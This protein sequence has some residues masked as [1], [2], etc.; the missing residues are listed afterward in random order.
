MSLTVVIPTLNEERDLPR[1]LKSLAN[2]KADILVIDSGS[3]DKTIEIAQ[4]HGAKI[5]NHPF[6]SFS[7]TRNFADQQIKSDWILSLEA[8]VVITKKLAQEIKSSTSEVEDFSAYYIP[9]QNIIWG[10]KINHTDWGPKDDLHIWLYKKGAGAWRGNVHEEYKLKK[11]TAGYLNNPLIHYNYETVN[12]FIGKINSYSEVAVTQGKTFP[13]YWPVRDFFKRYIYKL[14][15]LDGY[16][17]LFL[18][19]LQAVYYHTLKIKQYQN[20]V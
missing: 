9:R 19:Y 13:F 8:D 4:K 10:K 7:D 15:F 3:T 6:K 16:H 12:E 17:G 14:G 5:F 1:T 11:G 2:L 20:N 18:S